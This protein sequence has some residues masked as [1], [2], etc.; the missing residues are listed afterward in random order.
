MIYFFDCNYLVVGKSHRRG[1]EKHVPDYWGII[2]ISDESGGNVEI[3][4]IMEA[5]L[6][7]D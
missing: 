2:C 3:I 7:A 5:I 6:N 4:D 1:A